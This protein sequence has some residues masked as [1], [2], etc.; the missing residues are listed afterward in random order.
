MRLQ[1]K[2]GQTDF[3]RVL[4][5]EQSLTQQE[6]QLAVARS[7]RAESDSGV[8]VDWRRMAD[9]L[10]SLATDAAVRSAACRSHP[11]AHPAP[12]GP[13]PAAAGCAGAWPLCH[14]MRTRYDLLC[15]AI[16]FRRQRLRVRTASG[17]ATRKA[18]PRRPA[19]VAS[20]RTRQ[21]P[22]RLPAAAHRNE[23][24]LRRIRLVGRQ[25]RHDGRRRRNRQAKRL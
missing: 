16:R 2:E 9:T 8:Q 14:V 3:N 19:P 15:S 22:I 21:R 20:A 23:H 11:A 13:V 5:V 17:P 25:P 12:E 24:L 7:H 1:Y 10:H 4:N 18:A 6:D